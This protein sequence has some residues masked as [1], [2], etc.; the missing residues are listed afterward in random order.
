MKITPDY[1]RI[2]VPLA[3]E[4][5]AELAYDPDVMSLP[6]FARS[7]AIPALIKHYSR[8]AKTPAPNTKSVFCLTGTDTDVA[9]MVTVE[10]LGQIIDIG[11]VWWELVGYIMASLG[12]DTEM[13]CY[14]SNASSFPPLQPQISL[15]ESGIDGWFALHGYTRSAE[16]SDRFGISVYVTENPDIAPGA[17][18]LNVEKIKSLVTKDFETR[19]FLSRELGST[20]PIPIFC[21]MPVINDF[22]ACWEESSRHSNVYPVTREYFDLDRNRNITYPRFLPI[23]PIQDKIPGFHPG[24]GIYS[25][26]SAPQACHAIMFRNKLEID[27]FLCIRESN[28]QNCIQSCPAEIK[29]IVPV[30]H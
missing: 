3:P 2:W 9:S 11:P 12:I 10:L 29:R 1:E 7:I 6:S 25:W 20:L 23:D 4:V 16:L 8:I 22:Q 19:T 28:H 15:F 21:M 24:I 13:L 27:D 30:L 14:R 26:I 5:L 17:I 18:V